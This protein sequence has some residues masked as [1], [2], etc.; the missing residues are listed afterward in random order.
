MKVHLRGLFL[1]VCL[2]Q[3]ASN[4]A[5][6]LHL[7][8]SDV[9][10]DLSSAQIELCMDGTS[11]YASQSIN[12]AN[13]SNRGGTG[14]LCVCVRGRVGDCGHSTHRTHKVQA[15]SGERDFS[16]VIQLAKLRG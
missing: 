15:G 8:Q 9:K 11:N 2:F 16:G 6:R 4:Q 1:G 5:L 12:G 7:R 13:T 14:K 3:Q 10:S